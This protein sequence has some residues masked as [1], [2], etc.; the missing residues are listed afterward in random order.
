MG[1]YY[2]VWEGIQ[3]RL[4]TPGA[5]GLTAAYNA[6]N[7]NIYGAELDFTG[8]LGRFTL[9]GSASLNDARLS[10]DFCAI[11]SRAN[12]NPYPTCSVA[13]GHVKAPKGTRL[14]NQPIFKGSLTGRYEF[15]TGEWQNF[16]QATANHQS[17]ARS[18]LGIFE[19]SLLGDT[20]GF[21][22]F[23]FSLGTKIKNSRIELFIQNAFDKR[24]ELNHNTFCNI[25]ICGP[26]ARRVYSIRPQ[27]FGIKLSQ[28]FD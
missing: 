1:R 25:T 28:R 15:A 19:D 20:D 11:Q 7:A 6:G 18:F 3:Y 26:V 8:R 10:T 16:L 27:F 5:N 2:D 9:S 24:G 13:D 17:G 14:P 23:D 4:A 12:P 22:T 21:T